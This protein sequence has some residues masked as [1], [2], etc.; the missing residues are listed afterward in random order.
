MSKADLSISGEGA[1]TAAPSSTKRHPVRAA[2]FV[3][4]LLALAGLAYLLGTAWRETALREAYLPD[5]EAQARR[6]SDD[7]RLLALLGGR[8]AEAGEYGAASDAL[9]QAIAVGEV[10]EQIWLNL[11][12]ATAANGDPA[13]ALADLRLGQAALPGSRTLA[14]ARE[15]VIALGSH[16]PPE[17]VAA[18]IC[19]QGP[20]LL[21]SE[22]TTG[23][24]LN[25]LFNWWGRHHSEQSGFATRQAWARQRPEDAQAQR[26]WGLAL[27]RNHRQLEAGQALQRAVSLAPDS[28]AA[29][30][31]LADWLDQVG[32]HGKAS[33]QYLECLK[34]KPD[35]L[36]ALL[37]YGRSLAENGMR[38]R[39]G[40]SYEKATQ[41]APK[42]VEAWIGLGRA[43]QATG[44]TYD[45]AIADFQTA[46]RL[47]PERTDFFVDYSSALQ[48]LGRWEEAE[49]ITRR[50][51]AATPNDALAHYLLGRVLMN[52]NPTPSRENEAEAETREALR[53]FPHN[54]L[55]E[56]QL[57][58]ILLRQ[59]QPKEAITHLTDSLAHDPSDDDAMRVLSRAYR[60]VGQSALADKTARQADRLF[61]DKQRVAV[62]EDQ[63]SH[64]LLDIHVHEQLATLYARVGRDRKAQYERN[65]VR[66]LRTDP[67]G[68][69]AAQR[70][71]EASLNQAFGASH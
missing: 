3:V 5:L 18:A 69:A 17:A 30:L 34:R 44:A 63:E 2:L 46:A 19:P 62:L 70:A 60:V 42:S 24:F 43:H 15:R 12:A 39:S 47:A 11:A 61:Q 56:V 20:T 21:V 40:S 67:Q 22:Y 37:G 33:L 26:L 35:W 51:V 1:A 52:S 29:N 13:R 38:A 49:A 54:A 71:Y 7:G 9:R 64:N 16:P 66:L 31:A 53:L 58:Q 4:G 6:S 55:T 23:S 48:E 41:V 27:M 50:L 8:L 25:P 65:M 28:P 45:K 10:N 32:R 59:G 68:T 36:P 14:N 57:A